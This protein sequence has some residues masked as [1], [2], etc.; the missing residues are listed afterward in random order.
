[1]SYFGSWKKGVLSCFK[2]LIPFEMISVFRLVCLYFQGVWCKL[3]FILQTNFDAGF[4]FLQ[5]HMA[6]SYC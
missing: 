2:H 1:M 4:D 5:L 6:F 3:F